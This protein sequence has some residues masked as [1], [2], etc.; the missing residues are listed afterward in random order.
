MTRRLLALAALCLALSCADRPEPVAP[1]W[2]LIGDALI[3][4]DDLDRLQAFTD[5]PAA[6]W[7]AT[8]RDR[9]AACRYVTATA[10]TPGGLV[11]AIRCASSAP[12]DGLAWTLRGPLGKGQVDAHARLDDGRTV[13]TVD[14]TD[15]VTN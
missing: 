3:L 9:L 4:I 14:L 2:S 15:D 6:A 13:I 10:E 12:P 8:V 7:A 5:T 11:E 1:A